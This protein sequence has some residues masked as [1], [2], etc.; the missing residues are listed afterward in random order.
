L[1]DQLLPVLPI[2]FQFYYLFQITQ[3]GSDYQ[4]KTKLVKIGKQTFA[5]RGPDQVNKYVIAL[6]PSAFWIWAHW[7]ILN[8]PISS[9]FFEKE[10][11]HSN[12]IFEIFTYSDPL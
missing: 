4:K 9:D 3:I 8:F 12:T 2:V 6:L 10:S 11:K 7:S 5:K 1:T